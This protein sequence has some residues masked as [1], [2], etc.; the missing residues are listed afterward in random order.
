MVTCFLGIFW[1]TDRASSLSSQTT[2]LAAGHLFAQCCSQEVPVLLTS[3]LLADGN[4]RMPVLRLSGSRTGRG[5]RLFLSGVWILLV[6]LVTGCSGQSGQ[7]P[8]LQSP[9]ETSTNDAAVRTSPVVAGRRAR[10]FIFA[11]LGD[12]CEPLAAPQ[13]SVTEPPG[14][15]DISFVADQETMIQASAK[16]TCLGQKA[17]GTGVY[18]TARV[19]EAGADR[20]SVT[21]RLASGETVTR[22][23]VVTIAN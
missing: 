16:G 20:F 10:V 7:T 17:K 1:Q 13:I 6:V 19:G 2:G 9:G 18:Y 22:S 14:K 21:A 3:A 5:P 8:P 12:K 11:G 23:F 4:K 15:G